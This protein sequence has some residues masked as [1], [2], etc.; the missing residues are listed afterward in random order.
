MFKHALDKISKLKS[1]LLWWLCVSLLVSTAESVPLANQGKRGLRTHSIDGV[2]RLHDDQVDLATAALILSRE[3][4]SKRTTHVYRRKIDD[5]AE[6]ILAEIN[7]RNL[8]L[9]HRAIS[10]IN[11][12]L[13][14]EMGFTTI[15]T[16]DNPNDLFLHVVLEEK[17]GYCLGLSVLYLSIAERLGLPIYGVVV[18]GH[19]FVRY[20]DGQHR[21]NIE[22]TS[23]GAIAPDEHYLSKFNPPGNPRSLYM[24]NLTNKQTLGCFFNNLGNCYMEVGDTEKAFEVLLRAVQVNPLLSEANMNLGNVYLKKKMPLQAVEQYEKALT[25]IRNDAKA[26]NNLA[27][28]YMQLGNYAKAESY[29]KTALSLDPEYIDVYRNLANAMQMQGRYDD[30]VS[31]LKAAVVLNPDDAASFLLLGQICL[32]IK[33]FS[34]AE[35]YLNKAIALDPQLLVAR[36]SL[37]FVYLE[38]DHL[39]W[40]ETAFQKALF[41]DHALPDAHLG[42]ARIYFLT[43]RIDRE[44]QSYE[45]A[46][47]YNPHSVPG[48]QNLGNAYIRNGDLPAAVLAFQQ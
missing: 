13:F 40:A 14:G 17:S 29:Y 4:G 20:D 12:Y 8:P 44:I 1:P 3:W 28:A 30:A 47:G 31:Q 25:I 34:D 39:Q 26:M 27:S 36:V 22:T 37:G 10:V 41:H 35:R 5:M 6:D 15:E 18:P 48:L 7:K 24:K 19:F 42:L 46:L 11:D 33:Q 45:A 2:F 23:A 43:D 16:A 9:D 32:Q 38:Q 21:Y